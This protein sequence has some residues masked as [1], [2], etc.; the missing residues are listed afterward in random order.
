MG[1]HQY[2]PRHGKL[3]VERHQTVVEGCCVGHSAYRRAGRLLITADCGGS[4]G[5]RVRLWKWELQRFA[6]RTGLSVTVCHFPPGTSKWNKIEH[7]MFSFISQN[8][9]GKPLISHE[10][11]INLIATTTS[12]T[13][14]TVKSDLDPNIYPPGIKA[15]DQQMAELRLKRDTYHGDWNYSLL[16]RS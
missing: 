13:G 14:L 1:E 8:W 16:P 15:S 5:N 11:I 7:R 12:Q 10:V 3:C 9:L 4:N 6:D 2:R